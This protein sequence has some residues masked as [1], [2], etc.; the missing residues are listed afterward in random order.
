[1]HTQLAASPIC[2]DVPRTVTYLVAVARAGALTLPHPPIGFE[3]DQPVRTI[4][5]AG[6]SALVIDVPATYFT[7][8]DA[9]ARLADLDW[10]APRAIR[11]EELVRHAMQTGPILP[12]P[13]GAVFSSPVVL[14]SAIERHQA[15]IDGYLNRVAGCCEF[16]VRIAFDRA[17]FTQRVVDELCAE[18]AVP[19]TPGARYLFDKKIREEASRAITTRLRA[20]TADIHAALTPHCRDAVER[21]TV[22][23]RPGA[24]ETATV[25]AYLVPHDN[26]DAFGAAINDLASLHTPHGIAIELTGPWPTYSFCPTLGG[27]T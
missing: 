5:I 20:R 8:P 18:R 19:A 1:M 27:S 16:G 2:V 6:F 10:L 26:A 9:E 7:G 17:A 21:T 11:H 24:L 25:L 15:T 14:A 12:V 13:L 4:D 22:A 3:P 23:A